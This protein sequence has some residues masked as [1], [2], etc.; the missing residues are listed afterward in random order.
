[1]SFTSFDSS[2]AFLPLAEK[3]WI[4]NAAT[5]TREPISRATASSPF[6]DIE[7]RCRVATLGM[8]GS[9][10]SGEIVLPSAAGSAP[11]LGSWSH[12]GSCVMV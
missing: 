6:F 8:P 12:R 5:A 11:R 4:V 1:L 2:S 9:P 7:T 3:R 10:G